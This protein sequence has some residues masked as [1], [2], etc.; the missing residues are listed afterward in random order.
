MLFEYEKFRRDFWKL[1]YSVHLFNYL[2]LFI[3]SNSM[4]V[5]IWNCCFIRIVLFSGENEEYVPVGAVFQT[6]PVPWESNSEFLKPVIVRYVGTNI[7]I[8]FILDMCTF[9]SNNL[10]FW[11]HIQ[12][13]WE[14]VTPCS[15]VFRFDIAGEIPGW[16]STVHCDWEGDREFHCYSTPWSH[17]SHSYIWYKEKRWCSDPIVPNCWHIYYFNMCH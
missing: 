14:I 6:E 16:W 11:H 4:T 9:Y 17:L 1:R 5:W 2:W 15:Q 12:I 7:E 8:I 13:G 3:F 10:R